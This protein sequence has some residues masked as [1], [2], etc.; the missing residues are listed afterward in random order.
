MRTVIR[1]HLL[2]DVVTGELL[3]GRAVVVDGHRIADV[4]AAGDAPAEGPAVA[5]GGHPPV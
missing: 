1:P 5:P 2:L 4:V 3:A